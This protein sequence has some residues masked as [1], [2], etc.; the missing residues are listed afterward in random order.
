M[1]AKE[2]TAAAE[3]MLFASGEPLEIIRMAEV[4][5]CDEDQM[6]N[7]IL[8]LK[9]DL[10]ERSSGLTLLI[11]GDKCQLCSRQEFAPVIREIL[12]LKRNTP[13]SS[14]AFEVLAVIAYNQPVT[15]SFIEQIRGVD[16]SAVISTL[17]LR[18]LIEEKG[19]LELPGRPLLYGTTPHFLRCFCVSDLSELPSLPQ[20][21]EED[22]KKAL[23]AKPEKAETRNKLESV[24][25]PEDEEARVSEA[26]DTV[27]NE[28]FS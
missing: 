9:T 14:A 22:L 12:D 16:C 23:E 1:I 5:E 2:L 11:L 19:R 7:V 18:G 27:F 25:I 15:K 10:E 20:K 21:N 3:A 17:C 8:N 6:E 28:A 13:L 4:L 26:E 24:V